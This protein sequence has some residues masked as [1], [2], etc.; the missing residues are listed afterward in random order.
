MNFKMKLA[1]AAVAFT[2]G[3]VAQA[4][5][6]DTT[7]TGVGKGSDIVVN[8]LNDAGDSLVVNTQLNALDLAKGVITSWT[9]SAALTADISAFLSGSTAAKFWVIGAAAPSG[10]ESYALASS[11]LV[12][13]QVNMNTYIGNVNSYIDLANAGVFGSDAAADGADIENVGTDPQLGFQNPNISQWMSGGTGLDT[14]VLFKSTSVNGFNP[15]AFNDL[16]FWT[17]SSNGELNYGAEVSAVP[18]PAAVWLF[19]SGLLGLVGVARRRAA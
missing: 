14:S 7:S 19:G 16:Q 9:S 18:V 15:V 13:T 11:P 6:I 17:L 4:A 10:F 3:S 12:D 5:V 2:M 1:A 8:I